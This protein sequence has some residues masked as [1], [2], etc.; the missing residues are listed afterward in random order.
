[1]TTDPRDSSRAIQQ[2]L[3]NARSDAPDLGEPLREGVEDPLLDGERIVLEDGDDE[4]D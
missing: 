3:E 4:E 1:M 2:F